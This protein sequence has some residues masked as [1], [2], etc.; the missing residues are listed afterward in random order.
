MLAKNGELPR[1]RTSY[2]LR[3]QVGRRARGGARGCGPPHA[4]GPQRHRLHTP[5]PRG[6]RDG[7][8]AGIAPADPRRGGRGVRF[9]RARPSFELL[10][11][12]MHLASDSAV[13]RRMKDVPVA[14]VAF[15]LLWLEGHSTLALPYSDRRKLLAEPRLNGA[16]W[17]APAHREGDGRGAA[18]GERRAGPRGH[19]GQAARLAVRAGQ[20]LRRRGSR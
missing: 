16:S 1:T 3:D 4:H 20:A 7:R 5:V 15:D 2:G 18:G 19:R 9:R 11:S 14:Y 10:Q 8:R 6:P 12:R 13:R 17:R